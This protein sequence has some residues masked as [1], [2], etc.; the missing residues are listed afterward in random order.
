[1]EVL[2]PAGKR[3]SDEGGTVVFTMTI[4][5]KSGRVIRRANG[6]P[7]RIVVRDKRA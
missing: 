6:K 5:L 1:M 3:K 2:M 7:F 4:R